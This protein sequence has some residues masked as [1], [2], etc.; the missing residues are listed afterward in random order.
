[1]KF[2]YLFAK[3]LGGLILGLV[4]GAL[5][6]GAFPAHLSEPVIWLCAI[7]GAGIGA[8]EQVVRYGLW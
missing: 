8:T 3:A 1:M 7:A 2:Q 4:V 6:S 5:L